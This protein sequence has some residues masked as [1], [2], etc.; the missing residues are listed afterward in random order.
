MT[1]KMRSKSSIKLFADDTWLLSIVKDS[2]TS[3]DDL[4][5]DLQLISQWALLWEMSFNPDPTKPVEEIIFPQKDSPG[6]PTT[7][8]LIILR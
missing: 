4:N 3:A 6:S 2:I 8:F 1:L 7:V 5:H